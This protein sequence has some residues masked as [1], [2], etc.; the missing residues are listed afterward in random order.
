MSVISLR[1]TLA[2]RY[3]YTRTLRSFA[4]VAHVEHGP[5]AQCQRPILPGDFY[6]GYVMVTGWGLRVVK[7]HEQCPWDWLDE[8]DQMMREDLA[9]MDETEAS[10]ELAA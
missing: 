10:E 7:Y 3:T 5:C 9:A 4:H 2:F 6:E 1:N 8:Q